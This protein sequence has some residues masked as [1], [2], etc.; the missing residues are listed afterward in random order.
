MITEKKI[1]NKEI[2]YKTNPNLDRFSRKTLFPE[3]VVLA[4]KLLSEA[5]LPEILTKK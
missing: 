4:N 5:K 2:T 3:K 1:K